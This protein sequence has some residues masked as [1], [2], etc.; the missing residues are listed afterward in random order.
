MTGVTARTYIE[1]VVTVQVGVTCGWTHS[2]SA[3]TSKGR[4]HRSVD[5]MFSGREAE[6]GQQ[7]ESCQ[8]REWLNVGGDPRVH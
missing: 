2:F 3:G 4:Q 5:P 1:L 6:P 7:N 8:I